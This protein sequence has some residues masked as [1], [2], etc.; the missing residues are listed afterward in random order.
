MKIEQL[1]LY[2]SGITPYKFFRSLKQI[3][4]IFHLAAQRQLHLFARKTK[5]FAG[6]I[7]SIITYFDGKEPRTRKSGASVVG[8]DHLK[9]TWTYLRYAICELMPE[10]R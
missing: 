1:T 2:Q 6:A 4:H 5:Y 8:G 9:H 10:Q 7:P 3:L